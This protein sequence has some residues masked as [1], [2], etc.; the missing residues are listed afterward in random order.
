MA[1]LFFGDYLLDGAKY[2]KF[3]KIVEITRAEF[4]ALATKNEDTLYVITDEDLNVYTT[5]Q[6]DEKIDA[7][8]PTKATVTL[9]ASGWDSSALTQTVTV[10]GVS[11]DESAQLITPVPA[12]ASQA[13][14]IEAQILCTGQAANSLTFTAGEIPTVDLIV[15]VVMQPL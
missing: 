5:S 6:I 4:D 12:A 7:I 2:E 15:N 1:T 3:S 10:T 13:A 9:K 8:T 14:Y 11:A